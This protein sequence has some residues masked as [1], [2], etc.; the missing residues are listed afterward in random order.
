MGRY[1]TRLFNPRP[2]GEGGRVAIFSSSPLQSAGF[3]KVVIKIDVKHLNPIFGRHGPH[4]TKRI[5]P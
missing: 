4:G 5:P 2:G 1:S 3:R